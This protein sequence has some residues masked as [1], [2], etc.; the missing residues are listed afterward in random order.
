MEILAT[1]AHLI[2]CA[3]SFVVNDQIIAIIDDDSLVRDSV[4]R[5]VRSMGYRARTFASTEEFLTSGLLDDVCCVISDVD[6]ANGRASGLPDHLASIGYGIP[7]I[8]MTGRPARTVLVGVGA[9][10]VLAKP[11]HQKDMAH[12]I[13]A[14]LQRGNITNP[15]TTTQTTRRATEAG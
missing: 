8:F 1:K 3:G 5:L 9:V 10:Q 6:L 13:A 14:A 4:E 11:F 2:V 12:H 15:E 7:V